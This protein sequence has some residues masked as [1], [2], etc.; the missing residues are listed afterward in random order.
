MSRYILA[1]DQ[2]TQGTK[3]LLFDEN[4]VLA[5]RADRLHRQIV[6]DKGWVEHDPIEIFQ[7]QNV[8]SAVRRP[9]KALIGTI[10]VD[11]SPL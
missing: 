3:G 8:L 2:S 5:A 9:P 6:N 7:S 1:V 10:S 4:G 11:D